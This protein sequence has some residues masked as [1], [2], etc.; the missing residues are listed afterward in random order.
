M[1]RPILKYI[2]MTNEERRE[3]RNFPA[4]VRAKTGTLNFVSSLAGYVQT[5]GGR[6]LAFTIFAAEPEARAA[7]KLLPDDQPPGAASWNR[8]ATRLQQRLLQ[9]WASEY[10]A[11]NASDDT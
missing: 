11:P 4:D 3:I 5:P 8:R 7:G 2:V 6:D 1:L 10:A 9:R